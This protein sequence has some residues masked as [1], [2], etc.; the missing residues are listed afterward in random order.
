MRLSPW[1]AASFSLSSSCWPSSAERNA[2]APLARPA[3]GR[4]RARSGA[5]GH[6]G[7]SR[8]ELDAES[9][10][11]GDTT[12]LLLL[13]ALI[14]IAGGL[15]AARILGPLM[16]LGERLARRSSIAL[17]LALLALARSPARTAA[18]GAFLV[19]TIALVVFAAA[20]SATLERGARDEAAFKVPLDVT[21]ISGTSLVQPLDAAPLSAYERLG[22]GVRAYPVLRTTANA[23]GAGTSVESPTVLGIPSDAFARLRWRSD[24]ADRSRSTLVAD[25]APDRD[26]SLRGVRLPAGAAEARLRVSV[27]GEPLFVRV[28]RPRPSGASQS[29]PARGAH[30]RRFRAGSPA[31]R[32]RPGR[33]RARDVVD[34]ARTRVAAA[35]RARGSTDQGAVRHCFRGIAAHDRRRAGA[36]RDRL[37][38]LGRT[39][40][41]GDARASSG[42]P[43]HVS[44]TPSKTTSTCVCG[45]VRRPMARRCR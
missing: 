9:G 20:Y 22:Q 23:V 2:G 36:S 6:R 35:P 3:P 29:R 27:R 21:L 11:S 25:V 24:Y 44:H 30:A 16:V 1:A 5:R 45:R 32:P 19:V 41:W 43:R 15:V 37:A 4:G 28:G 10:S 18:A 39:R 12:F 7:I 34:E 40:T 8:G 38:R 14:C 26:V 33:R 17:R 31:S 13:P 42:G